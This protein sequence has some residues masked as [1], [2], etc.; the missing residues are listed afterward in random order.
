MIFWV[1]VLPKYTALKI[2]VE[3]EKEKKLVT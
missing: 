3:K 1:K 2:I